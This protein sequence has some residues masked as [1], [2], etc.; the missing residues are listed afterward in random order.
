VAFSRTSWIATFGPQDELPRIMPWLD[1][2]DVNNPASLV[3]LSIKLF[4]CRGQRFHRGTARDC[5]LAASSMPLQLPGDGEFSGASNE[6][7]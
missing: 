2:L 7:F 1:Y 3:V 5:Y 6:L 4:A